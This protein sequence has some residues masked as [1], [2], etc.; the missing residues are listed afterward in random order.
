MF[1]VKIIYEFNPILAKSAAMVKILGNL[2]HKDK[3][4]P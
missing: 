4:W 2:I 1:Q 3:E